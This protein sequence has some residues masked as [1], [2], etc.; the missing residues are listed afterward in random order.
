M[1]WGGCTNAGATFFSQQHHQNKK[2]A[3]QNLQIKPDRKEQG[4][5]WERGERRGRPLLLN[6][7]YLCEAIALYLAVY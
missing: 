4:G 2:T 3:S 1:F 7:A 6:A 5:K